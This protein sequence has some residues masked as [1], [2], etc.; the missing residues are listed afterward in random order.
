M[1]VDPV[2]REAVEARRRHARSLAAAAIE[3][4]ASRGIQARTMGSLERSDFREDSDVD[5]LV[6][7]DEDRF[8]EALRACREIFGDFPFDVAHARGIDP[9]VVAA[10]VAESTRVIPFASVGRR[11]GVVRADLD[12]LADAV[13]HLDA[14]VPDEARM[15]ANLADRFSRD[16]VGRL[17]KLLRRVALDAGV[18]LLA[19]PDLEASLAAASAPDGVPV[20]GPA[21]A[22]LL[23]GIRF[24]D[25][26]EGWPTPRLDRASALRQ[27]R[28]CME[29]AKAVL[30]DVETF[31]AGRRPGLAAA[32]D[33]GTVEKS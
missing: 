4:L 6:D 22:A 12:D 29:A 33:A 1:T 3:A 20:V 27:A 23:R 11:V 5:L 19:D 9:D 2:R 21:A 17:R 7:C 24:A 30:A 8:V 26:A 16:L 25:T 15:W 10:M 18:D 13:A 31:L 32:S 14:P 28:A